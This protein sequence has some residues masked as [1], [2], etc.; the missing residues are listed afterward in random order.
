MC[1]VSSACMLHT[2]IWCVTCLVPV[3]Y[4]HMSGVC[5]L[6][7]CVWCVYVTL[8]CLVCVCYIHVSGVCMLHSCLVCVCYINVSSMCALQFLQM[9]VQCVPVIC[10]TYLGSDKC[11]CS[12]AML[13]QA[14]TL[15]KKYKPHFTAIFSV[16]TRSS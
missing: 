14:M 12:M 13:I 16:F 9:C 7:S 1:D 2:H 8:M 5:M 11:T 6:H 4:I 15:H 10:Y 3:C